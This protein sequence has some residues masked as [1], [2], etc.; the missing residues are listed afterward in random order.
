MR[1]LV[2]DLFVL[3]GVAAIGVGAWMIAP[4]YAWCSVG[5]LLLVGGIVGH[6]LKRRQRR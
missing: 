4:A 6:A 3:G 1:D 2:L 5:V